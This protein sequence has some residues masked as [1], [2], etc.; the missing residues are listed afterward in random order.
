MDDNQDAE[1]RKGPPVNP[2]GGNIM[3]IITG[4]ALTDD[5]SGVV[6]P[7]P[8]ELPFDCTLFIILQ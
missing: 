6:P 1:A 7:E 8:P 2:D 4:R 5:Y 3:S